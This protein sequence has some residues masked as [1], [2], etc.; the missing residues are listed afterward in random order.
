MVRQIINKNQVKSKQL[1]TFPGNKRL[2][3]HQILFDR[4]L[5]YYF[6]D[7]EIMNDVVEYFLSQPEFELVNVKKG[8]ISS[9]IKEDVV[10]QNKNILKKKL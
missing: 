6:S 2:G 7:D 3:Q 9:Q 4:E 10:N 1:F 5:G 8:S